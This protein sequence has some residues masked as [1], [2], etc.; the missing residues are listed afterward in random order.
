M[1]RGWSGCEQM[2]R[3]QV[4]P[5]RTY[6]EKFEVGAVLSSPD[7]ERYPN[8]TRLLQYLCEKHFSGTAEE[9]KEYN[10]ALD[11]FQRSPEFDPRRHSV[12]R[13]EAGRLRKR[14]EA[15]YASG[16]GQSHRLRIALP[17]GSY[18]PRFIE[19]PRAVEPQPGGLRW[20][21]LKGRKA[22]LAG[23]VLLV[24]T[25]LVMAWASVSRSRAYDNATAGPHAL[26][27]T[28]LLAGASDNV[29]RILAGS[30]KQS[31]VD[32]EGNVWLGDRFFSGGVA[33]TEPPGYVDGV[34]DRT[35]FKS[36]R[37]GTFFSYNI[38]LKRRPY[39]LRLYFVETR[40]GPDLP[41]GGGEN[42]RHMYISAAGKLLTP[43]EFDVYADAGGH[44]I[45]DTRVFKDVTP[46]SDGI[47]HLAFA[48]GASDHGTEPAIVNA[49]EL[50]PGTPG[51]LQPIYITTA[52]TSVR[53][54]DR[55]WAS[56]RYF[57]GGRSRAFAERNLPP[58]L[59]SERYGSFT[60]AIP[61]PPGRYAL[62]L[63]F[64]ETYFQE[65]GKRVFDVFCNGMALFTN[66]DVFSVA[67][68]SSIVVSRTIHDLRPDAQGKL[69]VA[70]VPV[71]N[72]ALVNAIEVVD[73]SQ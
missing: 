35:P 12:V 63:H 7:F 21:R 20:H 25:A 26:S 31:Y 8:T 34:L 70:F 71:V 17:H 66:F 23:V 24:I 4:D 5:N 69:L 73:E 59:Q 47:L 57:R 56:D 51:K 18:V 45:L 58:H 14:L 2:I 37:Q 46:E 48:S 60:Y 54:A 55:S 19:W 30:T 15:Y 41:A 65:S 61:V 13:V 9:I 49:I 3:D 53:V 68:G 44:N 64:V 32:R 67:G 62:T 52:D 33:V 16:Q 40:F 36:S 1:Q 39:E 10:I 6:W 28:A 50:R 72:Y 22:L 29:V 27:P 43:P 38:P 11:V 42:S